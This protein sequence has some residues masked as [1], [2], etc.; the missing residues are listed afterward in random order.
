MGDW[1]RLPDK[2]TVE[3]VAENMR[4]RGIEV[5]AGS[6]AQALEIIKER[7]PQGQSVMNGTSTTLEQIGFMDHLA[8]NAHGWKSLHAE[9]LA[10]NDNAKRSD[11][12]RK[13]QAADYFLASVNAISKNGELVSCDQSGSRVGAYLFA[14]KH[15][16]LVAG[17]QK[18]TENL[19]M[20]MRRVREYA[21]PL[22]DER[23]KK[24]YGVGSSTSKWAILEKDTPGRTLLIL[25]EEKLGY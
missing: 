3:E 19:E 16:L 7:I 9:V 20:A 15:L 8:G 2:K 4:R 22:E 1:D 23:A 12:R 25:V 17:C 24:A 14:A 18:I 6:G 11:L 21:F 5:L 10:E 13:A